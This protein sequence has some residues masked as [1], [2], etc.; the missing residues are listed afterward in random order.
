M[1]TKCTFTKKE[2]K[3]QRD[4]DTHKDRQTKEPKKN[5]KSVRTSRNKEEKIQ[6]MFVKDILW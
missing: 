2:E 4:K 3:G 6:S 1:T 5:I